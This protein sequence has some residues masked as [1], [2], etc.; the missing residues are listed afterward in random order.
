MPGYKNTTVGVLVSG[1]EKAS[2]LI[3]SAI[4]DLDSYLEDIGRSGDYEFISEDNLVR[5]GT[6]SEYGE[7][8]LW[9]QLSYNPREENG[10]GSGS[11]E[12]VAT[13]AFPSQLT[14][15]QQW[16]IIDRAMQ[17]GQDYR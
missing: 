3:E 12:V 2:D 16:E 4:S 1:P 5:D 15:D 11:D 17:R 13:I 14:E 7:G 9:A 8:G 10:M 6:W